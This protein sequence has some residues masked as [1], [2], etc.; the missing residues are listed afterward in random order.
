LINPKLVT[1]MS[2]SLTKYKKEKK[3]KGKGGSAGGLA[4]FVWGMLDFV[5]K[6]SLR[7]MR[8]APLEQGTGSKCSDFTVVVADDKRPISEAY[9]PTLSPLRLHIRM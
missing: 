4:L 6:G 3:K 7:S 1:N 5:G 9:S 2:C 8:V